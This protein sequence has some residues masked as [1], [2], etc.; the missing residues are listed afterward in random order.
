MEI[1]VC[2]CASQL[3]IRKGLKKLEDKN[4]KVD[5]DLSAYSQRKMIYFFHR[6]KWQREIKSRLLG[7]FV[8]EVRF[9]YQPTNE[10]YKQSLETVEVRQGRVY[11]L[12]N[13]VDDLELKERMQ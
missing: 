13:L 10:E 12:G 7:L 1:L 11:I 8:D 2:V 3:K 9:Y 5:E 4:Y 6:L